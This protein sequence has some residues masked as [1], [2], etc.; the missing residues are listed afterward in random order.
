MLLCYWWGCVQGPGYTNMEICQ[1]ITEKML[2]TNFF[3]FSAFS[4]SLLQ[5]ILLFLYLDL[6]SEQSPLCHIPIFSLQFFLTFCCWSSIYLV[7][8]F[9]QLCIFGCGPWTLETASST[10]WQQQLVSI[11]LVKSSHRVNM[12]ISE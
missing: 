6:D 2:C 12:S 4:T 1:K 7:P 5:D 3:I 9:G 8:F 11:F 10:R